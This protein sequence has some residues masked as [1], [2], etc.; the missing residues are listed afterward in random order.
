MDKVVLQA[1][2]RIVTGKQV[3]ALRR[4]GLLPGVMYGHNFDP[5]PISLDL[6]TTTLALAGLSR[7]SL[8]Y[9]S[10]EGS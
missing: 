7:S 1:T 10:L 3:G 9:L 2:R 5:T 4:Q 8:V 6:H